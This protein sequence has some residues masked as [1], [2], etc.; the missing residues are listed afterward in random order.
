MLRLKF[1][2]IGRSK[3]LEILQIGNDVDNDDD[4]DH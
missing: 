2:R 4:D 3:I 1:G